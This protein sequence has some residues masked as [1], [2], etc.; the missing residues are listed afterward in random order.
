MPLIVETGQG[1][2][3]ADSYVSL[4]DGRALAATYGLELPEDDT[5]A[6]AALRN[7]AVH[8]GLFESQLWRRRVS[9]HQALAIPRTRIDLHGLPQHS[10]VI[11]TFFIQHAE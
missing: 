8:V 1:I 9:A 4:E 7:G 10:H 6:E 5:A 11:L 3:N 2:P